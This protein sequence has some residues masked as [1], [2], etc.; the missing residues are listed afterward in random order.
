[1]DILGRVADARQKLGDSTPDATKIRAYF[2]ELSTS[3]QIALA[4]LIVAAWSYLFP[5]DK[6]DKPRCKYKSRL[7]GKICGAKLVSIEYN[8]SRRELVMVCQ[9]GHK[10]TQRAM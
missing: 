5:R 8:D 3:D 9:K 10:T 6:D 4:S 1:M 2:G 7:S